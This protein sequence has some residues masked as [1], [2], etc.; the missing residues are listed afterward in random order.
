MCFEFSNHTFAV[1]LTFYCG[2]LI[3]ILKKWENVCKA[4]KIQSKIPNISQSE[5]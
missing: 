4:L 2:N 1:T 5:T 3:N